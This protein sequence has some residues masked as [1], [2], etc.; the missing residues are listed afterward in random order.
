MH[1]LSRRRFLAL[2]LVATLAIAAPA[3]AAS[4]APPVTSP[5]PDAVVRIAVST[6]V[7]ADIVA[8]AAG[9][10]AEVWSIVPA[11]GD[12]HSY[13]ATPR[14][15]ERA[16]TADLYVEMG[17]N[18]ERYAES[19]AWRRMIAES[20]IPVVRLADHVDLIVRDLVIDHGDHVHDLRDGDPHAW[21]DPGRVRQMV[22]AVRDALIEVDPAGAEAWAQA[23]ADWDAEMVALDT[24]IETAL[25]AIP[26]EARKLVVLHDAYA[27]LADRYGFEVLGFVSRSPEQE[28]SAADVAA[29]LELVRSSGVPAVFSEPQLADDILR[30]VAAEA[31]VEVGVLLTDSFTAEVDSYSELMRHDAAELVRLLG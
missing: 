8:R 19:G 2:G 13:S 3:T 12:P 30:M 9:P 29:L 21:F 27:Y 17:A 10:R 25:A 31:G 18:L 4:P 1:H 6:P 22:A 11:T 28:P 5:A 15:L 23:A 14:D 26:P 16:A 7:L 24:E 20:G